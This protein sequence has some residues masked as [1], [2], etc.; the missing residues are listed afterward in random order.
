MFKVRTI[1]LAEDIVRDTASNTVTAVK[2]IEQ[3]T[4][5]SF[6]VTISKAVL[7]VLFDSTEAT[8][9]E[10]TVLINFSHNGHELDRASFH[11]SFKNHAS[12]RLIID[13]GVLTFK[14]AGDAQFSVYTTT[15]ELLQIYNLNLSL[16]VLSEATSN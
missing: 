11:F 14:E 7:Y 12:S 9:L 10:Q 5:E 4:A 8:D 13:F 3:I 15:G 6:P 1:L 2:L 16:R